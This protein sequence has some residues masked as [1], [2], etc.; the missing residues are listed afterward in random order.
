MP[1]TPH[2]IIRYVVVE[3]ENPTRLLKIEIIIIVIKQSLDGDGSRSVP[4]IFAPPERRRYNSIPNGALR[5]NTQIPKSE[6]SVPPMRREPE[7]NDGMFRGSVPAL[8]GTSVRPCPAL[9]ETILGNDL[10]WANCNEESSPHD[11]YICVYTAKN[12]I[13]EP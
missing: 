11:I 1:L 8:P 12:C 9:S 2:S 5:C 3:A 6:D 7:A 13:W 4:S 10:V